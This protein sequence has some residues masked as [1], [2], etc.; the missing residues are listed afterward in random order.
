MSEKH[1]HDVKKDSSDV[2]LKEH[3]TAVAHGGAGVQFDEKRT[4]NLLWKLDRNIVPFLALLYLYVYVCYVLFLR[5]P[6]SF[7]H[8]SP[9]PPLSLS[10]F[11]PYPHSHC[12]ST[13]P[14]ASSV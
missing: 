10:L 4:K 7:R 8:L 6:R 2:S 13:L 11:R 14:T 9:F 12:L 1:L 3:H 5:S